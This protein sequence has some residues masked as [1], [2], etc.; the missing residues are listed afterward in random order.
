MGPTTFVAYSFGW[1]EM[2]T[3]VYTLPLLLALVAV[4]CNT[5]SAPTT[6]AA[7]PINPLSQGGTW[8]VFLTIDSCVSTRTECPTFA[9]GEMIEVT[10]RSAPMGQT[11]AG[12]F[13]SRT[14][15]I[16]DI[17]VLLDGQLQPD[18]GARYGGSYQSESVSGSFRKLEVTELLVR[19]DD[20]SGLGGTLIVVQT[21][22]SEVR[23]I[24]ATVRSAARQPFAETSR[25]FQGVFEGFGTLRSCD[26]TCPSRT[27]GSRVAISLHLTQTGSA[28]SG[29]FGSM[30]VGGSTTG[31]TLTVTGERRASVDQSGLGTTLSRIESLSGAIDSLG[32]LTGTLRLY[33]E[34]M[35]DSQPGAVTV[36]TPYTERLAIELSA[37]VR[38]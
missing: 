26:G 11:L 36:A 5:P 1:F 23:T 27:P 13:T 38:Q 6:P 15:W 24:R 9:T 30:I 3:R 12:V 8:T 28:V 4:A 33:N 16:S 37:V 35:Y 20:R 32:R 21:T 34:G 19:P 22:S 7:A 14:V 2:K 10:I 29:T 31:S 25:T 17:P 18:G